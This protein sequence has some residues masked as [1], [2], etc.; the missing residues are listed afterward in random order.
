MIEILGQVSSQKVQ[1]VVDYLNKHVE[2]I[3]GKDVSNYA[4]GRKRTW[5]EYEAP[6]GQQKWQHGLKDEYLW[7]FV[8]ETFEPYGIKPDLGLVSKAGNITWHRDAAYAEFKSFGINL[9]QVTWQYEWS[10]PAYA[11]V[12]D[13]KKID[14]PQIITHQ[15]TGGEIFQFN[16]KNRHQAVNSADDRW[17]FNLWNIKKEQIPQRD[18]DLSKR[19]VLSEYSLNFTN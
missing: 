6:L 18:Y 8:L 17:G 1:A 5:L 12:P 9:G 16:S 11:W 3:L 15:M 14:P 10:Y 7:N 4:K 13:N 2:P 19:N